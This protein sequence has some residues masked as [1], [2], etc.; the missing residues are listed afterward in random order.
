MLDGPGHRM[1]VRIIFTTRRDGNDEIYIMNDDGSG[2]TRITN[3]SASDSHPSWEPFRLI[4]SAAVGTLVSRT[5][6][7]QNKGQGPLTVS[8][9]TPSGAQFTI[10]PISFNVA[11]GDSQN[12][13]VTFTPDSVG[14]AYDTLTIT[15]NDPDDGT[16]RLI[17]NGTG[18]GIQPGYNIS[19]VVS[20]FSDYTKTTPNVNMRL[21][22]VGGALDSTVVTGA[23]G[24]YLFSSIPGSVDYNLV[25]DRSDVPANLSGTIVSL[26]DAAL[27]LRCALGLDICTPEERCAA[28]PNGDGGVTLTDAALVL[29]FALSLDAIFPIE[30]FWVFKPDTATFVSLTADTVQ[31]FKSILVGDVNGSFK[32]EPAVKVVARESHIR[33]GIGEVKDKVGK[34]I[35]VPLIVSEVEDMYGAGFTIDYP[36]DVLRIRDIR[37]TQLTDGYMLAS[38]LGKADAEGQVIFGMINA[39][40]LRGSGA[41]AELIFEVIGEDV[42]SAYFVVVDGDLYDLKGPMGVQLYDGEFMALPEQAYLSQNYPNPFNPETTIDYAIPS[43][44]ELTPVSLNIY[45]ISG[46]VVRTLVDEEKAPGFYTAVWDGRDK[47]DKVVSSGIYFYRIVTD[48][49]ISVKKMVLL[50]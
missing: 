12:V 11:A 30:T 16:V 49:F 21:T 14:T 35:T 45:N 37:T 3:N 5:M 50:K 28:D 23:D 18:V 34:F 48:K 26:T 17:V 1:G 36:D 6:T 25:P 39:T 29:R 42:K 10:T 20:Y 13:T 7:I 27:T 43:G 46:Q 47:E 15:S 9:I 31:N 40:P 22:E 32:D 2:L 38:N 8:N 19:G 44:M 33:V 24:A 4:G 41:I